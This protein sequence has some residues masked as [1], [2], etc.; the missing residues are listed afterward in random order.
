MSVIEVAKPVSTTPVFASLVAPEWQ[1]AWRD[2]LI[3]V[4]LWEGGGLY[5]RNYGTGPDGALNN[6]STFIPSSVGPAVELLPA[7]GGTGAQAEEISFGLADAIPLPTTEVTVLIYQEKLDSTNRQTGA[8]GLAVSSTDDRLGAHLPWNDGTVYW[9]FGTTTSGRLSASGLTF[10]RNVWILNGGP[11]G[12]EI[13]Q[14]G[15][16]RNS[17]AEVPPTRANTSDNFVVGNHTTYRNDGVEVFCFCL[18]S[19][20]LSQAQ[21]RRLSFDPFG[22][23]RVDIEHEFGFVAAANNID[24]REKRFS[25]MGM[26]SHALRGTTIPLFEADGAV[27]LDDK[28]HL[29]GCY[30]G[31]AFNNIAPSGP[32]AGSLALMGIGK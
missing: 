28:Q 18:W 16:L 10:G 25:I 3:G 7:N 2:L 4:P 29:L 22:M 15:I 14:D 32:Q 20:Q 9:D 23:F 17:K 24:T 6:S 5:V 11:R 8:F 12:M 13:W 26:R 30:S 27:D 19:R 1:W 21:C 31:I